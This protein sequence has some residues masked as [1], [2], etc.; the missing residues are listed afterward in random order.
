M[1]VATAPRLVHTNVQAEPQALFEQLCSLRGALNEKTKSRR[2]M[3]GENKQYGKLSEELGSIRLQKKQ[4]EIDFDEEHEGLI[5]NIESTKERIGILEA[6]LLEHA[7]AKYREDGSPLTLIK[8]FAN[9][10]RKNIRLQFV[11]R[12]QQ[13]TLFPA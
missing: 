5:N 13:M 1:S 4:I 10:K 9:G 2:E 7:L 6:Q 11:P 12:F 3:L 8:K